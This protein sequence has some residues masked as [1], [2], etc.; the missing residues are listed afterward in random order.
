MGKNTTNI[1]QEFSKRNYTKTAFDTH[2]AI[3]M[4]Q[5]SDTIENTEK[6]LL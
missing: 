2:K 5:Q 3:S 1:Q 4:A 6:A